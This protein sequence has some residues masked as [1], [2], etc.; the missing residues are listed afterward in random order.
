MTLGNR[1]LSNL[2]L[3][4]GW[5]TAQLN[6]LS[7]Q[8]GTTYATV[9]GMLNSA[10]GGLNS[11][12]FNDPIYNS[13]LS[14][15][16]DPI[17]QYNVGGADAA[18]RHTEYGRPDAHRADLEGHM[19]PIDAWDRG[20]GWTWD[21]LR[22]ANMRQVEADIAMAI[23]AFRNRW[24]LEILGRL[25]RRADVTG[26]AVG[27]G[28]GGISPGFATAAANT[29]VDYNPP[30]WGGTTFSTAHE[31]YVAIAGGVPTAAMF[32]D[33]EAELR[34]H[35]HFAPYDA[36]ISPLDEAAVRLITGFYPIGSPMVNYGVNTAFAN[37]TDGVDELNGSYYIG[38][39]GNTRIRVMPRIPQYY[40]FGFKSYG[41]RSPRNPLVVRLGVGQT[42]PA[43]IAMTDPRAG[44]ATTP[45]QYMMLFFEFGVGVGA[46]RTVAT[47][48]YVNNAT[49]ADATIT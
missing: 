13:L 17:V 48:R 21:Y 19:L 27:L 39:I 7:L 9:A 30:A 45:L 34:E 10:V 43:V 44:N 23:A 5:D 16:N 2:V 28:A 38:V 26:A 42:S 32:A 33:I 6:A 46:D 4:T 47:P 3:P 29:G 8:D 35:G 18:E 36:W 20:L 37:L 11:M 40:V 41:N 24:Q 25:F 12:L 14:F 22:K 1:D 15:T 31:H 49:W